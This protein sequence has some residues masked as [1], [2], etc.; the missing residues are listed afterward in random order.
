MKKKYHKF[1]GLLIGIFLLNCAFTSVL[2]FPPKFQN[3]NFISGLD[4]GVV[5]TVYNYPKLAQISGNFSRYNLSVIMDEA[6]SSIEG[7]LTVDFY[8]N[9]GV[10]YTRIPFHIYLSGMQYVSRPGLILTLLHP[11]PRS[12]KGTKKDSRLS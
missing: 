1:S 8:N 6:S 3:N 2:M 4:D 12:G 10:N 5:E 11:Q 9:D 7:N